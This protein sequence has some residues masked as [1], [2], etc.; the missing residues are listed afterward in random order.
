M[1]ILLTFCALFSVFFA[2][3]ESLV[4]L[5][6][7]EI[8]HKVK[9]Q[10]YADI[11]SALNSVSKALATCAPAHVVYKD[12]VIGRSNS[13]VI[14]DAGSYCNIIMIKDLAWVYSCKLDAKDTKVLIESISTRIESRALLGDFTPTE[15]SIFFNQKKCA[16]KE[17]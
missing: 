12:V 5:S 14:K 9:Q 8:S 3:A 11:E 17:L 15:Q 16:V 7:G 13:Y 2:N 4:N 1:R 6:V 10:D